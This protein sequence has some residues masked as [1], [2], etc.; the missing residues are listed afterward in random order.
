MISLLKTRKASS[1]PTNLVIFQM[2]IFSFGEQNMLI[3]NNQLDSRFHTAMLLFYK[4][5]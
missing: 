3:K 1:I 2:E 5:L 4:V